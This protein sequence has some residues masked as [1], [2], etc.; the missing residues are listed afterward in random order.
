MKL[1]YFLTDVP[2][3]EEANEQLVEHFSTSRPARAF[4]EASAL[5]YGSTVEIDAIAHVGDK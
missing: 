1:T 2:P 5:P 3:R 4:L